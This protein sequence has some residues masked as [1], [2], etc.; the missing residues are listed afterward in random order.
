ME[1]V[2]LESRD[3]LQDYGQNKMVRM[4]MHLECNDYGQNKPNEDMVLGLKGYLQ[5]Y[6]QNKMVQGTGTN[7]P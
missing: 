5:D 1:G 3:I 7:S 6:G 4:V 2:G